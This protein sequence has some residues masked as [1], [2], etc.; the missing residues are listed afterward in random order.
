MKIEI[1]ENFCLVRVIYIEE[2]PVH[3]RSTDKTI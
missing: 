3:A 1:N 2:L